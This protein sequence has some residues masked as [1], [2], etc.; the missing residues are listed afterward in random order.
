[1]LPQHNT[2]NSSLGGLFKNAITQKSHNFH[3]RFK[4]FSNQMCESQLKIACNKTYILQQE[5][6]QDGLHLIN[7]TRFP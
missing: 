6:K 4:S 7:D 2:V 5:I 1:M 3:Q